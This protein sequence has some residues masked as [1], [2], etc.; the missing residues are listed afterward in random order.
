MLQW[1]ILSNVCRWWPAMSSPSW[2]VDWQRRVRLDITILLAKAQKR[3]QIPN[4]LSK[5]LRRSKMHR[6]CPRFYWPPWVTWLL[7]SAGRRR[8]TGIPNDHQNNPPQR[9]IE[10]SSPCLGGNLCFSKEDPPFCSGETLGT[11][12]H[13]YMSTSRKPPTTEAISLQCVVRKQCQTNLKKKK[14]W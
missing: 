3:F 2:D 7:T 12:G 1:Q 13:K 9:P 8:T 11:Q 10:S 4:W 5:L 6:F 14:T